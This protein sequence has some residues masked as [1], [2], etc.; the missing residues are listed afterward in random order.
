MVVVGGATRLTQSGLSM[1][2]WEPVSG[3]VPPLSES[4]WNTEFDAYKATPEGK[5]INSD[6]TL[7][8]FKGIFF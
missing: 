3:I 5:L 8:E 2:H 7:S 6:M 1:V 4:S